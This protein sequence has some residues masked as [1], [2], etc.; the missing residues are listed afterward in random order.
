MDHRM[1]YALRA[2][3]VS[4][5]LTVTAFAEPPTTKPEHARAKNPDTQ[6]V[7]QPVDRSPAPE[8]SDSAT[9]GEQPAPA[10]EGKQSTDKLSVTQHEMTIDGQTL[11]YKATAG[12]MVLKDDGEKAKANLFFVAYEKQPAAS[13]P[14]SRPITF[15]FNGGPGAAS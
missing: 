1:T 7:E 4:L 8:K 5:L 12:T 6:P 9:K 13:D 10:K 11:K 3:F 2:V 14:S 15:V